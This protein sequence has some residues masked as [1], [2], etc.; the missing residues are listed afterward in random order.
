[1]SRGDALG[2]TTIHFSSDVTL[3]S[4]FVSIEH[5]GLPPVEFADAVHTVAHMVHET[6]TSMDALAGVLHTSDPQFRLAVLKELA[7]PPDL[8]HDMDQIARTSDPHQQIN[9][10]SRLVMDAARNP[11][12]E[13]PLTEGGGIPNPFDDRAAILPESSA[14]SSLTSETSIEI[15][16]RDALAHVGAGTPNNA[17]D[18]L[19]QM[20]QS[21]D[22]GQILETLADPHEIAALLVRLADDPEHGE[23]VSD[24]LV[25][26]GNRV[27]PDLMDAAPNSPACQAIMR[28]IISGEP[29]TSTADAPSTVQD[30]IARLNSGV[31]LDVEAAAH[32]LYEMGDSAIPELQLA[33]ESGSGQH[34]VVQSVIRSIVRGD[35]SY[36]DESLHGNIAAPDLDIGANPYGGADPLGTGSNSFAGID[37]AGLLRHLRSPDMETAMATLGMV[38][39]MGDKAAPTLCGL[40]L[41][42]KGILA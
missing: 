3:D 1:M 27:L 34:S 8:I 18:V 40:L 7:L 19:F 32:Q 4:V 37:F 36:L 30:L 28:A 11:G 24:L 39:M 16:I 2:G 29:V 25:S 20:R 12:A 9:M 13:I 21:D 22:P 5:G 33:A 38:S 23:W 17:G 6:S 26:C 15:Q 41:H 10:L 31:P 42:A 35:I 14:R